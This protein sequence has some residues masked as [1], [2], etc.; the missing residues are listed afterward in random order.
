MEKQ[1]ELDKNIKQYLDILN[2]DF[3]RHTS[4]LVEDFKNDVR[5]VSEQ[6]VTLN[7]KIDLILEDIDEI[8]SNT[9]EMKVE[10]DMKANKE[11]VDA[12]ETRIVKLEK[13]SLARV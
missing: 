4:V 10:S 2:D 13:S 9:Q 11:V 12:H 6:Y 5:T 8:K 7:S 3:K 1:E